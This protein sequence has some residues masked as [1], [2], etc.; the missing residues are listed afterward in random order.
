MKKKSEHAS[1]ATNVDYI[2]DYVLTQEIGQEIKFG[3]FL[4]S[5]PDI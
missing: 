2:A 1:E 5:R 3:K 4:A